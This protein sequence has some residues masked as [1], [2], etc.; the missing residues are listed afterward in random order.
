MGLSVR[1]GLELERESGGYSF[2]LFY[3]YIEVAL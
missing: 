3:S 1:R 2:A